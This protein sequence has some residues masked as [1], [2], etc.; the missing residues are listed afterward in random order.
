MDSGFDCRCPGRVLADGE[1]MGKW[2]YP[3]EDAQMRFPGFI[4]AP[5]DADP[6]PSQ[7]GLQ[8]HGIEVLL[9]YSL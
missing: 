4:D 5:D 3:S 8:G 6:S 9:P 1:Q 2:N 7:G